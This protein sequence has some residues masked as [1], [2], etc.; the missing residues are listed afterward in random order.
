METTGRTAAPASLDEAE[1][2]DRAARE[3]ASALVRRR[4]APVGAR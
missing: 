4:P 1:E 2:V 3:T